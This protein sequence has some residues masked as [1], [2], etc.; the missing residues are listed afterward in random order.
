M[1]RVVIGISEHGQPYV[2]SKSNNVEVVFKKTKRR[3]LKKRI[4][5]VRYYFMK[6]LTEIVQG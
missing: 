1:K 2:V 3:S 6:R 4:K 5:T